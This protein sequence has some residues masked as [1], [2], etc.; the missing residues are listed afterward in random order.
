MP[1]L[2]QATAG[3]HAELMPYTVEMGEATRGFTPSFDAYFAAF[4]RIAE[5]DAEA[6]RWFARCPVALCP[7]APDVA[8]PVGVFA[9]P[10]VDGEPPRPGGKLSLCAYASALGLPALALP[11][12]RSA[13]GLPVGV[14]LMARR[15]QELTLLA[16]AERLE[17]RSAAGSIP[18]TVGRPQRPPLDRG[19]PIHKDRPAYNRGGRG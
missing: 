18:T 2:T 3:R 12:L 17:R 9:F 10:P 13:A 11:V 19:S 5:I 8:P 6:T 7:V 4:G 14:Q 15:G 1:A 16:I